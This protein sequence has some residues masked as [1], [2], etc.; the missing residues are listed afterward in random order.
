MTTK[1]G[2]QIAAGARAKAKIEKIV[3]AAYYRTC[4]GIQINIMDIG[5]VFKAGVAAYEAGA[6]DAVLDKAV[7]DF[8]QTIRRN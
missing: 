2:N 3:E 6:R 4:S 1:I 5:K 7:F 8:V